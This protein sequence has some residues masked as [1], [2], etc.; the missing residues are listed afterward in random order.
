MKISEISARI[1]EEARG[2]LETKTYMTLTRLNIPFTRVDNDAVESMEE[3]Q[4]IGAKLGAE[5][6]KNVF[7][8]DRK[9]AKFYLAVLP[10]DKHFDT[11]IFC[12]RLGCSRVSFAPAEYMQKYL[13]VLPGTA[14]VMSL[15]NDESGTVSLVID[16]EVAMDEWF[17]CNPGVNTAH[18]RVEMK[19]LLEVFLPAIGHRA[20]IAGL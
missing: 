11:K 9:K 6:R 13:G 18:L 5:I 19:Q 8:C 2:E 20:T 12:E 4:E 15:L 17:A 1:P 10:A 16:R 3:C 7:L 14:S